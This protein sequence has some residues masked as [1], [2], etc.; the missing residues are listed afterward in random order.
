MPR[1]TV[2]FCIGSLAAVLLLAP[3]PVTGQFETRGRSV[4]E[5]GPYSIAVGDFNHDGNLDLAV[6]S[7][8]TTEGLSVLLGDGDGTFLPAVNYSTGSEPTSV[9]AA[10]FNHDGNLDLAV[11]NNLSSYISLFLGNGDGTFAPGPQNPAVVAPQ[12][13][14][15][16]GDFNGDGVADLIGLSTSNPCRCISVFLGNG[17]GT[18]RD[19]MVT[20]PSFNVQTIG[21]GDFNH[22]GKLDVVT[23]GQETINVL[24]GNG[25]GTFRYGASYPSGGASGPIAVAELNGDKNLDLAV[26]NGAGGSINVLLGNGNGTFQTAVNYPVSFPNWVTAADL[27][28]D[29]KLDLIVAN[30][31][32]RG[33]LNTSGATI[34]LGNGDGTFQQPG[35]FYQAEQETSYVA[36]GDFNGDG[37][38]DIAITDYR[39]DDV[40]LMLNTGVV[41]FSPST[42]LLFSKQGVGTTSPPQKVTLTNTGKKALNIASIQAAGQFGMKTTCGTTVK[43]GANC[44]ISVTFSPKTKGKVSGTV[45][46]IDN[47]STKPQVIAMQGTGS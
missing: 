13:F 16:S 12:S 40:V 1:F 6:A 2:P 26:A 19:A 43:S 44:T 3:P 10:D 9:V 30:D 18:F 23:A 31:F 14:V 22:D 20:Q 46:I 34:F 41:S 37:S 28:G 35:R 4:A 36:V 17:D 33:R 27:N 8:F 15:A 42:M 45:T 29:H 32:I 38:P 25:D 39:F 47:A 21:I 11:A 24:L 5:P 7:F